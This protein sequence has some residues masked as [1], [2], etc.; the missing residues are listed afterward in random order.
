MPGFSFFP[1]VLMDTTLVIGFDFA[2]MSFVYT[3]SKET[4]KEWRQL[5]WFKRKSNVRGKFRSLP[6]LKVRFGL[7][8]VDELTSLTVLNFCMNQIVS[9]LLIT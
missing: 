9:L 6:L 2:A 8:F 4:M 1:M 5:D 3:Q 7:N